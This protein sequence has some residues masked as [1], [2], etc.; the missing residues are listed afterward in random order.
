MVTDLE[1]IKAIMVKECYSTFTNRRKRTTGLAGPFADGIIMVKDDRWKRMR[2][3]L[4]PYFTSG[5]LK[6]IFPIAVTHAD[7][8][9]KNMQKKDEQPVK[10]KEYV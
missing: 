8:F 9:I 1:M 2:S 5:R 3:T 6:E 7:R 10:V 4:S